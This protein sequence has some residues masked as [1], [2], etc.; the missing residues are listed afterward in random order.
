MGVVAG[1]VLA[2]ASPTLATASGSSFTSLTPARVLD[3]RSG[4]GAPQGPVASHTSISLTIAGAGGVPVS[5]VSAVVLNVTA[6]Q[7]T[8]AGYITVYPDG[9]AAPLASNL[10]FVSGQ[11]VP[12]LVVVAVGSG[13]KVDFFNG[14]AGTVH[15]VADV[16]G[17]FSGT[18]GTFESLSPSR[19][20][21]TRT[22]T[23]APQ[24]AVASHST[25]TLHIE[26]AGGVPASG[27]SAV[28]LNVTVTQPTAPGY[29]TVYP[30]GQDAPLASNL[31]FTAGKTVPNLVVVPVGVDG[32]VDL[33]NG[34]T[35]TVQLV[36]DVAGCW[37]GTTAGLALP[38]TLST[39]AGS[40][41]RPHTV[42]APV[43][44]NTSITL[45]VDGVDGIP[46]S[47]VSSVVM[48]VTVAQPTAQGYVTVYPDG[49]SRPL[50]SNLNFVAGET[51]P[52][53]VFATVGSDGKVDFYNGS[54]G[55]TELIGDVTGFFPSSGPGAGILQP[56]GPVRVLDTRNGTGLGVAGCGPTGS[57]SGTVTNASPAAVA[58][59][60]V[61]AFSGSVN[62][63]STT[64]AADGT[65][66]VN[67]LAPGPFDVCFDASSATSPP[68]A[69]YVDQCYSGVVWDGSGA[70][71][72]GATAVAVTAGTT[73]S[74]INAVLA[75]GGG[76]SG[77]VTDSAHS[78]LSGVSAKVFTS[79]GSMLRST[80]T[81]VDGTYSVIG[82]PA[83]SYEV[84]FDGSG[85]GASDQCYSNVA[86]DGAASPVGVA[87]QVVVTA[88]AVTG[89]INATLPNGGAVSGSVNDGHS[90]ALNGVTV[91]VFSNTNVQV[92]TTTTAPNGT[93]AIDGLAAGTDHVCFDAAGV[94]GGSSTT[95]Y[96]S[97]CYNGVSWDAVAADSGP[98]TG[99]AVIV[100]TTVTGINASLVGAGAI[101][102]K[103]TD[104][105]A[106][107]LAGVVVDVDTSG[108]G[109]VA[110]TTT[111]GSGNF[112]V[113]GLTAG[114]HRV[115]FDASSAT[116]GTS[117]TGYF[118]Q[119]YNGIT[120]DG[121]QDEVLA[122][123]TAVAVTAG[124]TTSGVN[125]T[126]AAEGAIS[127][128]V[129]DTT[130]HHLTSVHV[131]VFN[132]VGTQVATGSTNSNGTYTVG[133][134]TAGTYYVCFDGASATGSTSTHGYVDQCYNDVSWDGGSTY[135]GGA[136]A[137]VVTAGSTTSGINGA[138][139]PAV[140][141]ISG[142]V[143]DTHSNHLQYVY[144]QA[145][146]GSNNQVAETTSAF[147]GTYTLSGLAPG[148]YHVCFTPSNGTSGGTSTTGYLDQCYNGVSWDGIYGDISGATA[149]PVTIGTTTASIDAALAVAGAISGTVYD[150]VG[151]VS[152]VT[153]WVLDTSLNVVG[154]SSTA[155][156][157]TYTVVGIPSEG[158]Y[159]CF[160][161]DQYSSGS[162]TTGYL[163]QCYSGVSWD[164]VFAHVMLAP[165]VTVNLNATTPS[166]NVELNAAGAI[167][168]TVHDTSSDPLSGVL[169]QVVSGT[170]Y[171]NSTYTAADGTYKITGLPAGTYSV[172][173][174]TFGVTGG[175]S[176][177]GYV[178]QCYSGVSW[179]GYIGDIS[180]ATAVPVTTGSTASS[181]NAA[182]AAKP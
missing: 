132:N 16:S 2:P 148:T 97:Q 99:V 134:L 122:G 41:L 46:C 93:Y 9:E 61:E 118:D 105:G 42:P 29:V 154:A 179:D 92:G 18:T 96:F 47:G 67:N 139:V 69:G 13:G 55:S 161:P 90:N 37:N 10:N 1:G 155:F 88:G 101:S 176:A 127:G 172:C 19:V 82:L 104:A 152:G 49:V 128:T 26:G 98:A 48:N 131:H 165:T 117:T 75:A 160:N 140:G 164:G 22:G 141:S 180:G 31:N 24:A 182:L 80:T 6:T 125:A 38:T 177:T 163:D 60:T 173:F 56:L 27:V 126:L 44:A 166:I 70:D 111:S 25:V 158:V 54:S 68:S 57:I 119:C 168:G 178:P 87:T 83:A 32:S 21:D 62:E 144:V 175:V 51:V 77:T 74:G 91:D 112:T 103:V 8:S 174:N 64:T 36:G 153:V 124:T 100:G 133:G 81:A 85:A 149:V 162:S 147:D 4:V 14:S 63:G 107:G 157:G 35:G 65:Y 113:G 23:G 76:I 33:Y 78:P 17:Y 58:G 3:T 15:L 28:I 52:N 136:A 146:D 135:G 34:S 94:T 95:G 73:T 115:C 43:A 171:I 50:A 40:L 59:V 86:W 72:T 150:S 12:N 142:T 89:G 102:G 108:G 130:A 110:T 170:G 137:V 121:H 7:P 106:N 71:I 84:C 151:T 120:W 114:T 11:T 169:V 156:N 181:I 167:S 109:Y 20:L 79:L 145:F 53:L 30:D 5:G 143:N 129:N 159:V 45:Q 39:R 123:A 138:L 116:G 66:Q